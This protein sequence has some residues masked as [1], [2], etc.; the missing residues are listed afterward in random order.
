MP[1]RFGVMD[2]PAPMVPI[3]VDPLALTAVVDLSRLFAKAIDERDFEPEDVIVLRGGGRRARVLVPD[4]LEVTANDVIALATGHAPGA[5]P[6]D[7]VPE[8]L[9]ELSGLLGDLW[10]SATSLELV[11]IGQLLADHGAPI[12][13][14]DQDPVEHHP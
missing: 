12:V 2:G 4:Y 6:P 11:A 1:G 7:D 13:R 8:Y 10:G 14:P 3:D 5:L 9:A